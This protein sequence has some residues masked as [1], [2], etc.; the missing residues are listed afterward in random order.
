MSQPSRLTTNMRKL[1]EAGLVERID[2]RRVRGTVEGIYHA[3]AVSYW[4]SPNLVGR[5]GA[6]KTMSEA[7]LSY[8]LGLAEDLQSDV[9]KLA[10]APEPPPCL[11]VSVHVDVPA[12]HRER[13]GLSAFVLED[14]VAYHT[15]SNKTGL[16]IGGRWI[17]GV[18][19][20]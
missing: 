6:R 4:L 10:A 13:P 9:S 2:E 20:P 1:T 17:F 12:Y 15:Y 19:L 8:L 11:G 18:E 16:E 3:R 14:G 5:L 7:G